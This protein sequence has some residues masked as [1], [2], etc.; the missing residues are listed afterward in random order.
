MHDAPSQFGRWP[1]TLRVAWV[2]GMLIF[3]AGWCIG[4]YCGS[5]TEDAAHSI[6]I[7]RGSTHYL[8]PE[9][10][11]WFDYLTTGGLILAFFSVLAVIGYVVVYHKSMRD[12]S[13]TNRKQ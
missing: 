3:T 12:E 7:S 9:Q 4:R 5:P 6:R 11:F 8:T 13:S 2:I 10:Y 1:L